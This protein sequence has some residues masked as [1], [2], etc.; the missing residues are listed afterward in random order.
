MSG[1]QTLHRSTPLTEAEKRRI[2][3]RRAVGVTFKD[4]RKQFRVSDDVIKAAL[5]K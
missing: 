5:K 3:E 1:A 4:L 2:R